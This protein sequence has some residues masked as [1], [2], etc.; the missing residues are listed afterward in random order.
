MGQIEA[1]INQNT[2]LYDPVDVCLGCSRP[3]GDV[4]NRA[5]DRMRLEEI[6]THLFGMRRM[7]L[8]SVSTIHRIEGRVRWIP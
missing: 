4:R 5:R 6:H 1:K 2:I 8:M 3:V 7:P